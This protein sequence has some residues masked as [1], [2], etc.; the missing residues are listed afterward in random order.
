M[1]LKIKRTKKVGL[2]PSHTYLLLPY[3]QSITKNIE[4][5]QYAMFLLAGKREPYPAGNK[6]AI[7]SLNSGGQ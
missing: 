3:V 4:E 1:K 6:L 7:S 2:E 5:N